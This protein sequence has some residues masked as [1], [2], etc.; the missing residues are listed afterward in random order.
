[1]REPERN[2]AAQSKHQT[3]LELFKKI[4]AQKRSDSGKIYSLHEPQIQC[5]SRGKE[6]RKYEFGNK[7]SIAHTQNT[8]VIVGALGFRN[9]YDGHT[10][11]KTLEQTRRLTGKVP[12]TASVD[13]GYKGRNKMGDTL[14]QLPKPFNQKTLTPYQQKNAKK[15]LEEERLL[16]QQ[17]VTSKQTTA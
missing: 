17:L 1:V 13:R 16:N 7:V 10:L 3:K 15:A 9:E 14:V 5:I 8:G 4:L 2:V 6:H 12:K 11:E